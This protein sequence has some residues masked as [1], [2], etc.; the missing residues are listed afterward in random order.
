MAISFQAMNKIK[1]DK[2]FSGMQ[3]LNLR[4]KKALS[5]MKEKHIEREVRKYKLVLNFFLTN[6]IKK[7]NNKD[8]PKWK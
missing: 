7:R 8:F 3:L 2:L 5:K 1:L 4:A 6:N